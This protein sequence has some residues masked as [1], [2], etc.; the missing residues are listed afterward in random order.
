[1][2]KSLRLLAA[3]CVITI[4]TMVLQWWSRHGSV[5]SPMIG[6]DALHLPF[7][8]LPT[9]LTGTTSSL[10]LLLLGSWLMGRVFKSIRLPKLLGYLVFGLLL[11]PG[12]LGVVSKEQLP[13]LEF[14]EHLAIALIALTAGGEIELSFLK[15]AL[16]L[17][18]SITTLQLVL[19]FVAVSAVAYALAPSVGLASETEPVARIVSALMIGGIA[20]AASPATFIAIMNEM[21]ARG[22]AV[23]TA[24]SILVSKDLAL[25]VLF[26]VLIA[27]AGAALESAPSSPHDAAQTSAMTQDALQNTVEAPT[28]SPDDGRS[29]ALQL[30]NELGGRLVGSL[31]LG[32][33]FGLAFAW[34]I[35]AIHAHMGIFVI[36]G[37]LSIVIVSEMLQ[38]EPLIVALVAGLLM[39]NL[40][41]ERVGPY[42]QVMEDLSLPVYCLFFAVAGARFDIQTLQSLW[43]MALLI[44]TIRA[45]ALWLSTRIVCQFAGVERASRDWMWTMF[46]PRAGVSIALAS[47]I[48]T[49]FS[50]HAFAAPLYSLI[51]ATIAIDQFAG[52]ILLKMGLERLMSTADPSQAQSQS[53]SEPPSADT[54]INDIDVNGFSGPE[55]PPDR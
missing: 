15:R 41:H 11:G 29:T 33:V 55:P 43:P 7:E 47:I 13:H 22:V 36:A 8:T 4:L 54:L 39:R 52:P 1:M 14:V 35:H 49:T 37:C 6:F 48:T 25:I 21:Q 53:F 3:L 32:V 17:I 34:Y 27:G 20:T 28:D 30:T 26:T 24:L 45:G 38:I 16:V 40:W 31:V 5:Q 23:Q 10:G 2:I 46:L 44:V 51:I 9:G 18:V 50:E 12:I 42:F 19:V